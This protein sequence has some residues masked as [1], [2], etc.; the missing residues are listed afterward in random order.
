MGLCGAK[1]GPPAHLDMAESDFTKTRWCPGPRLTALWP[2]LLQ[3][4][5]GF[6]AGQL[7]V[8]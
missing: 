8:R 3:T 1:A 7:P 6:R 5:P 2:G 4:R